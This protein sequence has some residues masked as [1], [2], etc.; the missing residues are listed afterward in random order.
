MKGRIRSTYV[1]H[2]CA[3]HDE[4][5]MG[6]RRRPPRSGLPPGLPIRDVGVGRPGSVGDTPPSHQYPEEC[7]DHSCFC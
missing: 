6:H 1:E 4:A 5:G 7:P 3:A 2:V